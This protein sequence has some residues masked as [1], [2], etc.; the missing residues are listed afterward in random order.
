[1]DTAPIVQIPGRVSYRGS[2]TVS[3]MKRRTIHQ[4]LGIPYALPPMGPLRFKVVF[5]LLC[6]IGR[7][8]T[9]GTC[10]LS[11]EYPIYIAT[12]SIERVHQGYRIR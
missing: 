2:A 9:V 5:S 6:T 4:Y 8:G 7:K 1:M 10:Y 3:Y 12:G 11:N